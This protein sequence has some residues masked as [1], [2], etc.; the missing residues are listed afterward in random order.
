MV[1]DE[2]WDAFLFGEAQSRILISLPKEKFTEM[3]NLCE[4]R[5]LP[6]VQIGTVGGENIKIGDM[7]DLPVDVASETWMNA[8]QRVINS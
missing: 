5:N 8:L 4:L 1:I 7:I 3:E 6:Y 2:R